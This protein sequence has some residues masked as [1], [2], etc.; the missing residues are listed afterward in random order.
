[1]IY[2][3]FGTLNHTQNHFPEVKQHIPTQ[4]KLCLPTLPVIN[5]IS[6]P[7]KQLSQSFNLDG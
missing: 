6:T 7:M 5:S 4:L 1:M 3:K 2:L